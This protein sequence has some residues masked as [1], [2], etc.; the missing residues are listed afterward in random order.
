MSDDQEADATVANLSVQIFTVPSVA[1]HLIEKCNGL[2]KLV[3]FFI[4]IFNDEAKYTDDG[5]LDLTDWLDERQ[6][7]YHR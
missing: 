4:T 5:Q 1:H 6:Y 7:D 2:S 3:E